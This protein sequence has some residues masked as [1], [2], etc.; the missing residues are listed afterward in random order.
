MS[1]EITVLVEDVTADGDSTV[2]FSEHR[3]GSGY[4]LGDGTHTAVYRASDFE[5]VIV[6]Q[7]TLESYPG[8]DDWADISETRLEGDGSTLFNN[9]FFGNFVWIRAKYQI[10]SGTIDQIV[11]SF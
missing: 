3:K 6:L 9:T 8:E 2:R 10:D 7:G 11:Y 1:I 5:G 4:H